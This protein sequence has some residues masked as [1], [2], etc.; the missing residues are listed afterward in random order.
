MEDTAREVPKRHKIVFGVERIV[1]RRKEAEIDTRLVQD[2]LRV[3]YERLHP[4]DVVEI[5][6]ARLAMAVHGIPV[7]VLLVAAGD[8]GQEGLEGDVQKA[9]PPVRPSFP[10]FLSHSL[11]SLTL[12][13]PAPACDEE[14]PGIRHEHLVHVGREEAGQRVP[15]EQ[16]LFVGSQEL[17]SLGF[18]FG[19]EGIVTLYPC[20]VLERFHAEEAFWLSLTNQPLHDLQPEAGAYFLDVAVDQSVAFAER[21]VASDRAGDCVVRVLGSAE[22][23][24]RLSSF[25]VLLACHG[26]ILLLR[27]GRLQ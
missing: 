27:W 11:L 7:R 5:D 10:S 4:T 2:E 16:E 8:R 6:G 13:D 25:R 20:R 18:S 3:G 21:E 9:L 14:H 19:Q 12:P 15:H 23:S 1:S 17:C 22:L 26:W 24:D